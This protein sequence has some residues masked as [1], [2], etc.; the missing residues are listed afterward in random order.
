MHVYLKPV[1]L[2]K[3]FGL[4]YRKTPLTQNEKSRPNSK[5]ERNGGKLGRGE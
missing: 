2:Q 5:S 3:G 1:Y 4:T